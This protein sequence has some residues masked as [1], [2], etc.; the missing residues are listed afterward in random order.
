MAAPSLLRTITATRE[1]GLVAAIV[2]VVAPIAVLN[3]RML[4]EQNLLALG[5]D[6]ALLVIVAAGQMIVLLTRNIDLSVAS[7]IGLSAYGSASFMHLNPNAPNFL[8]PMGVMDDPS[9]GAS[10]APGTFDSQSIYA[11]AEVLLAAWGRAGA[12][13]DPPDFGAVTSNVTR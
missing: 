4:G 9:S 6:A 7:V 8:P 1:M 11:Q 10:S 2:A 3:P 13:I 5:M 12:P